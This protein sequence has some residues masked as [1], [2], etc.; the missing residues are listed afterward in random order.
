MAVTKLAISKPGTTV[1]TPQSKTT[2]I[3]KA[4]IPKVRRE[5]GRAMIWSMGRMKVLTTPIT[6]AATI[7][8]S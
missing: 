5:I 1:L 4:E 3:R 8:A 6:M 7:A 2:L